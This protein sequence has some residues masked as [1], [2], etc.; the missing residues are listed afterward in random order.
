MPM[1]NKKDKDKI[2]ICFIG[3]NA[4]EVTGSVILIKYNNK[5]ILL[6]MG[7]YQSSNF[8]TDFKINS[9]P[10]K[11]F[12]AKDINYVFLNHTHFDHVGL[13]PKLVGVGFRGE[14][15]TTIATKEFMKPMLINS[16]RIVAK[17]AITLKRE[18]YYFE[19]DVYDA[20]DR[21]IGYEYNKTIW[22]DEEI[23]FNFL[24]NSHCTGAAQLE[25]YIKRNNNIEKILY[26]SDLGSPKTENHYVD[27]LQKCKK[28][29]IVISEATYANRPS[30]GKLNRAKDLEKLKTVIDKTIEDG[31]KVLIP[32]FAFGRSIEILTNIYNIYGEDENFK[33]SIICDS[34]LLYEMMKVQSGVLSEEDTELFNKVVNWKNVRFVKEH[35]ESKA[36]LSDKTPCVVLSSSGMLDKGRSLQHLKSIISKS[37]CHVLFCGYCGENTVGRKIMNGQKNVRIEGKNYRCNCNITT[38]TSFSGHISHEHLLSYLSNI[39]CEKV[40]LVHGNQVDKIIFKDTLEKEYG[41]KDSCTKVLAVQKGTVITI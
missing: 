8:I 12:K 9:K 6:E 37:N 21:T 41:K 34:P 3:E 32:V 22:L 1:A 36:L 4:N 23:G 26:T 27:D 17:D 24:N 5:Q 15:I 31:G 25:L 18:P 10:F 30:K 19:S 14:I 2:K 13:I 39:Q 11:D 35:S 7:A 20:I 29:R 28:A 16:A 40:A 33:T 38:L